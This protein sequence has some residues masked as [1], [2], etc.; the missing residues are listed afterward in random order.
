MNKVTKNKVTKDK[1]IRTTIGACIAPEVMDALY[2]I[3]NGQD[4]KPE[5]VEAVK[6]DAA[7]AKKVIAAAKRQ[8]KKNKPTPKQVKNKKNVE[9]GAEIFFRSFVK[10]TDDVEAA[11]IIV[12]INNVLHAKYNAFRAIDSL[13]KLGMDEEADK[14]VN[15]LANES[16][17]NSK[18]RK[19]ATISQFLKNMENVLIGSITYDVE[20]KTIVSDFKVQP[21]QESELLRQAEMQKVIFA[22]NFM[23][24]NDRKVS[25]DILSVKLERS[26]LNE[27][28]YMNALTKR[29]V[30]GVVIKYNKI[31]G[32]CQVLKNSIMK[33]SNPNI[34]VFKY[35][36]LGITPSG[37][38]S[39]T[40]M[41]G[42][43]DKL[44]NGKLTHCDKR[45]ELLDA[46]I[47]G[48]FQGNFIH[49][50]D[51]GEVEFNKGDLEKIFKNMSRELLSAP[52]SKRLF[53]AKNYIIVP[54]IAEYAQY[55][56]ENGQIIDASNTQDGASS[57]SANKSLTFFKEQGIK[58]SLLDVE[59]LVFQLRG[60][61]AKDSGIARRSKDIATL[62]YA[63]IKRVAKK[64]HGSIEDGIKYLATTK[65]SMIVVHDGV[66]Y[67]GEQITKELIDKTL[68]DID[69]LA[70]WNAFKLRKFDPEF[71]IV[72]L[73]QGHATQTGINTVINLMLQSADPD[74]AYR[75]LMSRTKDEIV[76]A[77]EAIGIKVTLDENKDVTNVSVV[78][79]LM[80][81]I[82]NDSQM[83]QFLLKNNPGF[84]IKLLPQI[85]KGVIANTL[86]SVQKKIHVLNPRVESSYIV[87]QS[88]W[89]PLFG[90]QVLKYGEFYSN[91]I[92]APRI[93]AVRHPISTLFS[94]STMQRVTFSEIVKRIAKLHITADEKN[95]L[96]HAYKSQKGF[97]TICATESLME[98]H[99]GMDFDIDSMA[100][101]TDQEIVDVLSKIE[102]VTPFIDR[103]RDKALNISVNKS[104]AEILIEAKKQ[105]VYF[106]GTGYGEFPEETLK[107]SVESLKMK[108]PLGAKKLV[109]DLEE[110]KDV[111]DM[112]FSCQGEVTKNYFLNPIAPIGIIATGFYNNAMLLS[113]LKDQKVDMS[114][115]EKIAGIFAYA[116]ECDKNSKNSYVSPFKWSTTQEG[117]K[118]I[119]LDKES[120]T[121]AVFNYSNS[122]GS[123]MDTL[124]FL[125]DCCNANRYPGETSIDSAKKMYQIIDM[126]NNSMIL[127]SLG[128]DKNCIVDNIAD[129]TKFSSIVQTLNEAYGTKMTLNNI[130]GI[131]LLEMAPKGLDCE[132]IEDCSLEYIID[133]MKEQGV[134]ISKHQ[135]DE[136][137][138]TRFTVKDM[139][140]NIKSELVDFTNFLAVLCSKKLQNAIFSAEAKAARNDMIATADEF[141]YTKEMKPFKVALNS[142]RYLSFTLDNAFSHSDDIDGQNAMLYKKS[143]A[144]KTLKN[145]AALLFRGLKKYE[146]GNVV[147]GQLAQEFKE[148][149]EK[150]GTIKSINKNF[151][152][153]FD[154]DILSYLKACGNQVTAG[155]RIV[156]VIK[157]NKSVSDDSII[158]YHISFVSGVGSAAED[159]SILVYSENKNSNASGIVEMSEDG[160][161]YVMFDRKIVERDASLGIFSQ[162]NTDVKYDI[163]KDMF[164]ITNFE[165]IE[166]IPY[167]FNAGNV[168]VNKEDGSQEI[169]L[170]MGTNKLTPS[171]NLL[172]GHV[173]DDDGKDVAVPICELRM[174]SEMADILKDLDDLNFNIFYSKPVDG[175]KDQDGY[176][177]DPFVSI[178]SEKLT[179]LIEDAFKKADDFEYADNITTLDEEE[180]AIGD[181][182][183]EEEEVSVLDYL[184]SLGNGIVAPEDSKKEGI[185]ESAGVSISDSDN[186]FDFWNTTNDKV[187]KI[188]T[189]VEDEQSSDCSLEISG[190]NDFSI[191]N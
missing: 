177:Y 159:D 57:I 9:K 165:R 146:I 150:D 113:V 32:K 172:V 1:D 99:D 160:H 20:D 36:F 151:F 3:A 2:A 115:K 68:K 174:T 110:S 47:A 46:A 89:A 76:K 155:E 14:I 190:E 39:G 15:R 60:A 79:D 19:G 173:T 164:D 83:N 72:C 82:N 12:E 80:R 166:F 25:F 62:M 161:A 96:Y 13:S 65:D 75:I 85:I 74:A 73:K 81:K 147:L 50:N 133:T 149:F 102:D 136:G 101:I 128:S 87:V 171:Y 22:D 30:N 64:V 78:P 24:F 31:S 86:K 27:K 140:Y 154:E 142:I 53:K 145:T 66:R 163:I 114:I 119:I 26:I 91:D 179:A 17:A 132:S 186:D 134:A 139:F 43:T 100:V 61:S 77:F 11:Q 92:K 135:L 48:G 34:D 184:K 116:Y 181:S 169:T 176:D 144:I 106:E 37:L 105:N 33:S 56:D 45:I 8:S 175:L 185:S 63:L 93:S 7:K 153:I 108:N 109:G 103:T 130:F 5:T 21:S 88:D 54:N 35:K 6:E 71:H 44:V 98:K 191:F 84:T 117:N 10:K 162:I 55:K 29:L 51:K 122:R 167:Q 124:A 94:V 95:F 131:T 143:I 104:R 156:A 126:F 127:R 41:L 187:D 138:K 49:T 183:D 38:R 18:T 148:N 112:S 90:Q 52:A 182:N 129:D 16:P 28:S 42:L 118:K 125:T 23:A 70:D 137:A 67:E 97:L 158:G 123:V 4:A 69:V 59:G 58:A 178:T 157:G 189:N 188:F 120:C 40:V 152:N 168:V 107:K 170:N 111:L 180:V 141:I 121:R